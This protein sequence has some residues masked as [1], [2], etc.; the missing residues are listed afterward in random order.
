[1]KIQHKILTLAVVVAASLLALACEEEEASV[2]ELN[3]DAAEDCASLSG[4]P[5][6][7]TQCERLCVEEQERAESIG[8]G[9][10]FY[11]YKDCQ[12]NL[13]CSEWNNVSSRCAAETDYLDACMTG[14]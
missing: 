3:C 6:S 13:T 7:F 12:T 4:Q 10:R 8:C 11:D 14:H 2:C 9:E 5:F 1:M